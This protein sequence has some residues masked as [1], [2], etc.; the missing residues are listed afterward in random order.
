MVGI[1]ISEYYM[2]ASKKEPSG[3]ENSAKYK[4]TEEQVKSLKE[5]LRSNHPKFLNEPNL[6]AIIGDAATAART[7][8]AKKRGSPE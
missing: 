1:D 2:P 4:F 7:K 3:D 6:N 8:R 5:G